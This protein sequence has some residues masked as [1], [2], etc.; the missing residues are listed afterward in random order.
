MGLSDAIR[1]RVALSRGES[2]A[3]TIRIFLSSKEERRKIA[4]RKFPGRAVPMTAARHRPGPPPAADM[5]VSLLDAGWYAAANGLTADAAGHFRERGLA[6]GLAPHAALAGPDGRHLSA[7]GAELLLR[8]GLPLGPAAGEGEPDGRDPWAIANPDGK[9]LAV[10]TTILAE[11]ERLTPVPPEWTERADF[12]LVSNLAF[13][14]SG[15]WQPVRSVYHHPDAARV[16]AFLKSHLP[17]FFSAYRR[18]LWI[19]P[20]VLCSA[21]PM[22]LVAG[23]GAIS[24]FWRDDVTPGGET[25]AAATGDAAAVQRTAELLAVASASPA[26]DRAGVLDTSVL[27]LDPA[28]A[29]VR[30]LMAGWWRYCVRA[31]ASADGLALTLAAADLPELAVHELPGRAIARSPAFV[32]RGA[33]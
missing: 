33:E 18:V 30:Q 1:T 29:A 25:A 3:Q 14:E 4:A 28:D 10:V 11:G 20:G 7:R 12:F 22:K 19:D 6:A 31:P 5:L 9:S 8:L 26:F 21:D 16:A 15:R 27:L 17:V 23:S 13:A 32:A 2:L 24:A